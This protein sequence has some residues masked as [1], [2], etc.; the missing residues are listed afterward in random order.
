MIF[1]LCISELCLLLFKIQTTH[2]THCN[3]I[4]RG[5]FNKQIEL[6][7]PYSSSLYGSYRGIASNNN[8]HSRVGNCS[9]H[10]SLS[11]HQSLKKTQP[12]ENNPLEALDL[13]RTEY[14]TVFVISLSPITQFHIVKQKRIFV[15][16]E[17]VATLNRIHV[18]FL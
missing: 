10:H 13:V 6:L 11:F 12:E 14:D 16:D 7:V 17:T 1:L 4:S 18:Q 2:G 15:N 3:L 5:T 9:V 8:N